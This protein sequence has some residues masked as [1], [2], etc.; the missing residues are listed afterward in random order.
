MEFI[1]HASMVAAFAL[2][3]GLMIYQFCVNIADTDAPEESEDER[4]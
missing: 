3:F 2:S 1:S 4:F